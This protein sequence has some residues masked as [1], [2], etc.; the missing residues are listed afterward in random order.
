MR[1]NLDEYKK[2]EIFKHSGRARKYPIETK[3]S[4]ISIRLSQQEYDLVPNDPSKSENIRQLILKEWD[5]I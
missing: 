3:F 1:Q 4:H 2:S 5:K